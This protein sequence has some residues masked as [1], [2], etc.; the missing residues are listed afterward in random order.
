MEEAQRREQR[1]GQTKKQTQTGEK[2][3]MPVTEKDTRGAIDLIGIYAGL[4][5]SS[6]EGLTVDAIRDLINSE[7]NY[8]RQCGRMARVEHETE[9]LA[10][11]HG[12]ANKLVAELRLDLDM[13]D[14]FVPGDRSGYAI[15]PLSLPN[16]KYKRL[17]LQLGA[18]PSDVET[19]Y[20]TGST[21]TG[22]EGWIDLR[23]IADKLHRSIESVQSAWQ[24]ELEFDPLL[25]TWNLEGMTLPKV[26]DFLANFGGERQVDPGRRQKGKRVEGVF[27]SSETAQYFPRRHHELLDQ[28][29]NQGDPHH[30]IAAILMDM[31]IRGR[32]SEIFRESK[33]L[34]MARRAAQ[35]VPPRPERKSTW[36]QVQATL[37]AE[38]KGALK[39]HFEGIFNKEAP[40][41]VARHIRHRR[42]SRS[43]ASTLTTSRRGRQLRIA[44]HTVTTHGSDHPIM[45]LGSP[46]SPLPGGP[47][48]LMA[49]MSTRARKAFYANKKT[50]CAKTKLASH[51]KAHNAIVRE[52]ELWGAPTWPIHDSLL[53][54]ANT[55]QL[56]HTRA[57]IGL[58]RKP[59]E[60]W[61]EWNTR[62]TPLQHVLIA[63]LS[64][65]RETSFDLATPD[66]DMK[67]ALAVLAGWGTPSFAEG[68]FMGYLGWARLKDEADTVAAVKPRRSDLDSQK[69]PN[70]LVEQLAT[71]PNPI[72]G[73][74][75][76]LAA[77]EG[78]ALPTTRLLASCTATSATSAALIEQDEASPDQ[79]PDD[80]DTH[81]LTHYPVPPHVA[82]QG[83]NTLNLASHHQQHQPWLGDPHKQQQQQERDMRT[84][85]RD[86]VAQDLP[87]ATTLRQSGRRKASRATANTTAERAT[88]TA[89]HKQKHRGD[90]KESTRPQHKQP[91]V[92]A[93]VVHPADK[94]D[95]QKEQRPGNKPREDRRRSFFLQNR[96]Q[97]LYITRQKLRESMSPQLQSE[98]STAANLPWISKVPFLEKFMD[99]IDSETAQGKETDVY[100]ACIAD[101]SRELSCGAFAQGEKFDN[102]QVLYIVS[103]GIVALNNRVGTNGAVWGEDF[104]LSDMSLIRNVRGCALTYLEVLYLTREKFMKVVEKRTRTCPELGII[105]RQFTVRLAVRRGFVAAA[106]KKE[107]EWQAKQ[108]AVTKTVSLRSKLS[109]YEMC[110]DPQTSDFCFQKAVLDEGF[111]AL[112]TKSG[113]NPGRAEQLQE[114]APQNICRSDSKA[115]RPPSPARSIAESDPRSVAESPPRSI[116]GSSPRSVAESH[117]QSIDDEPV[118]DLSESEGAEEV[119]L[120]S[121]RVRG[122]LAEA[123]ARIFHS[124]T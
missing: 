53:R 72:Q 118:V 15:I 109:H 106:K 99:F 119:Q 96:H 19:E 45:V 37:R 41:N 27:L 65:K 67:V 1:G 92:A 79:Q 104:V 78:G 59:G 8:N 13:K 49:E 4:R 85:R 50:L 48:H 108:L 122:E 115:R 93:A 2:V 54:N 17:L 23:M 113:Q 42:S 6:L 5:D 60:C 11:G 91:A 88:T 7:E 73:A 12:D 98:I 120:E 82:L 81:P 121:E 30:Q 16:I 69:V 25:C 28:A 34:K 86:H 52:A 61:H 36:K 124:S 102:M 3:E 51:L 101:V 18:L 33:E 83:W 117:A 24:H 35:L 103:K 14:T 95:Q 70:Q 39:T 100:R 38:R 55:I 58:N 44:G 26:L 114:C 97:A 74:A 20:S 66:F 123:R 112:S 63:Q 40:D 87:P 80:E 105:V 57:M 29:Y 90:P 64:L 76:A 77:P 56:Q 68:P 89:G 10:P 46:P 9:A 84:W 21:A 110:T 111:T 75:E 32:D 94:T 71:P 62:V 43:T 31:R 47:A 107:E 22:S 116:P